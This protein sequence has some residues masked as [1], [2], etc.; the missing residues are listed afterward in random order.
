MDLPLSRP[1]LKLLACFGSSSQLQVGA[2]H[3]EPLEEELIMVGEAE[4]RRECL[5]NG[6]A[7]PLFVLRGR[8]RRVSGGGGH[9]LTG[10]LAFED[11]AVIQPERG[12]LFRQLLGV[13]AA[14]KSIREAHALRGDFSLE[15]RLNEA[16]VD[17][18]KCTVEDLFLNMEFVGQ[19]VAVGQVCY[20]TSH[21]VATN[22]SDFD[23]F[24]ITHV[25]PP[26]PAGR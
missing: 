16:S 4:A 15:D 6:H 2:D 8:R 7:D 20:S 14:H 10:M 22:E 12:N 3:M 23:A 5:F 13:Y 21:S 25:L 18:L 19:S 17:I 26:T 24:F 11:F 9:W 1:F